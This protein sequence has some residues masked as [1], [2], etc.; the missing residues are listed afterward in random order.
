MRKLYFKVYTD[1]TRYIPIDETELEKAL[2]AFQTGKPVIFENGAATRIES[3]IPDYNKAA[4][5]YSDYKPTADTIPYIENAKPMFTGLVSKAKE[6]I[7]YL[8][9][10]KQE[11]LIGKN[12]ELPEL[13]SG[14]NT[15]LISAGSELVEGMRI[16]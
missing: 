7:Q 11:N 2:Y 14:H 3:V 5:Y 6:K 9:A 15:R 1:F 13:E 8:I 16:K 4:G 12:V 10:T